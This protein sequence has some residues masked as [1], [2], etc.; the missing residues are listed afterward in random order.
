[1][2]SCSCTRSGKSGVLSF[3]LIP[4]ML[5][6]EMF[7]HCSSVVC[8]Y[9]RQITGRPTVFTII[10]VSRF[11]ST[12]LK[13]L[14]IYLTSISNSISKTKLRKVIIWIIGVSTVDV[15]K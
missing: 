1:M 7:I 5:S 13:K 14:H 6:E 2:K 15:V 9:Y 4:Q 10:I 12:V 11:R 3:D 8:Y